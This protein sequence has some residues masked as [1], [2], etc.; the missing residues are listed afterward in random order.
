MTTISNLYA[1]C[2]ELVVLQAS[3]FY[4]GWKKTSGHCCMGYSKT[5][6]TELQNK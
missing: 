4:V 3:C 1:A 6:N 2:Y 5:Q